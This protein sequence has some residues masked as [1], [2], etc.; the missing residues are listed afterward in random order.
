MARKQEDPV[1][2]A[3]AE[4]AEAKEAGKTKLSIHAANMEVVRAACEIATL[5]DLSLNGSLG[6]LPPEIGN[7]T[8]LDDLSVTS[9]N[10]RA[11]PKELGKCTKLTALRAYSNKLT[12]LPPEL[13]ALV[14]LKQVVLFS[15]ELVSLPETIDGWVALTELELKWNKLRRLPDAITRLPNLEELDLESNELDELP[16]HWAGMTKLRQLSLNKNKLTTFPRGV[17]ELPALC[18]LFLQ[19]NQLVELP[20]DLARMKTLEVLDVSHNKLATMSSG[21]WGLASLTSLD[22]SDNAIVAVPKD[23]GKLRSLEALDVHNN[24]IEGIPADAIAT[25]RDGVFKALGLA[26]NIVVTGDL[27]PDN[28]RAV[29]LEARKSGVD[30]FVRECK[31]RSHDQAVRDKLVQFITGKTDV[32]PPQRRDDTYGFSSLPDLLAPLDEWTFVDRRV[33]KFIAS[34]AF[35]YRKPEHTYFTGYYDSFFA[36]CKKQLD[37]ETAA[38]PVWPRVADALLVAGLDPDALLR[39]SLRELDDHVVRGDGM[40]TSYGVWLLARSKHAASRDT[41]ID[42]ARGAMVTLLVRHDLPLFAQVADKLL[43]LEPSDSGEIHLPHGAYDQ[44]CA[45]DPAKYTPIVLDALGK[46]KCIGCTAEVAKILAER[47]GPTHR[48]KAREVAVAT[49]AGISD[50]RNKEDRLWFT[51]DGKMGDGVAHYVDWMARTFGTDVKDAIFAFAEN[52]K[53]FDLDVA[54]AIARHLKQEGVDALAEGLNMTVEDNDIAAHF[55]RM[56]AMLAP[57]DWSKYH[58]KAWE[59]AKS[60]YREVR[61]TA[62]FALSRLDPAAVLPKALEMMDG[63][64]AHVREA[65]V[66]LATLLPG[67]PAK[68]QLDALLADETSDDVRDLVVAQRYASDAKGKATA[69]EIAKRVA[70]AKARGKL[71][72]PVAKWLDEKKLGALVLAGGKKADVDTVRW[73]LHRQTRLADIGPEAEA[74][75]VYALVDRKKSGAFA[76]KL[77]A[78]AVKNGGISAKTRFACSVA[79]L[80]GDDAIVPTLEDAAIDAHNENAATALGLLG[81]EV[82]ARALD[83]IMKV[84]RVKYPNVREAAQDA[85]DRIAQELGVTRFELA[86]RMLP[87]FGFV[88]GKGTIALGKVKATVAFGADRKLVFTDGKGAVIKSPGKGLAG[89]AKE[90]LE[91]LRDD[92]DAASRALRTSLEYYMVGGRRW[93][94]AKWRAYFLGNPLAHAF[95]RSLVWWSSPFANERAFRVDGAGALVDAKG[96][97]VKLAADAEVALVHPL[98]L[99][100]AAR[101]AWTSALAADGVAPP[102]AQMARPLFAP[103]ADDRTRTRSF[104]FEDKELEGLTFKSRAERL[105]WRRG[106]VVD[107]GEVSA[108]RKLFERQQI[109]AFI[110]TANLGVRAEEGNE[111]TLEELFFVKAGAVVTGSYTYDE[112]RDDADARLIKLGD[113]PPIVYSETIAD[114]RHVTREKAPDADA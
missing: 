12:T 56:F 75:A 30:Q 102:F 74:R 20:D 96:V 90:A 88:K 109:E 82:A 43:V 39:S 32:V 105:G 114:L 98:D 110:G 89:K 53:V 41:M 13:G 29:I 11:L 68:R 103:N 100:D 80:V 76:A 7:L 24:P 70:S 42:A 87:D 34:R 40:P 63:K 59:L 71:A 112:P 44:L 66:L 21:L 22:V 52:T 84:F 36:W 65:G 25:G 54:E 46:T 5:Q 47:S 50:R 16:A 81:S 64:K 19:R 45:V 55:R 26:T 35:Y 33:V 93:P 79:G 94:A 4:I 85:F 27:P 3:M 86:D 61:Q 60:E 57:L 91:T 23:I 111:V 95:A 92:V 18:E 101:A 9:M 72:K 106:S 69:A 78:L 37:A 49:L 73:L 62:C 77:L 15:N 97:A 99:D 1:E 14:N 58:D 6:E 107:A 8:E 31:G 104:E 51:F 48:A 38:A 67:D 113:V 108:Y 28:E 2:K 10:L 83:R 17:L